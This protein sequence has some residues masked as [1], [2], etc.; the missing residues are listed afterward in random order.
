MGQ[1]GEGV[2]LD[3]AA[4]GLTAEGI[5]KL[6]PPPFYFTAFV[7]GE[8]ARGKAAMLDAVAAA[9]KFPSYFGRNWD[10]L[11]D[12]LR[13][14]PEFN[15]A[16]GYVLVIRNSSAFLSASPAELADFRDVAETAA[17][18]LSEKLK[19]PFKVVFL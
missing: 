16:R 12:C 13:S 15:A 19:I 10:A 14:L 5:E 7:D 2:F 9:F 3:L 4:R 11:L 6:F 8:K 1:P 17:V 18:F